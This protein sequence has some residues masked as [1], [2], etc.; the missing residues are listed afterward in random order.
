[1][2]LR[3]QLDSWN[4]GG[5]CGSDLQV[6]WKSVARS[7]LS[8]SCKHALGVGASSACTPSMASPHS[9]HTIMHPTTHTN[10]YI[11]QLCLICSTPASRP[12]SA[13]HAGQPGYRVASPS[14]SCCT[15][16]QAA[17]GEACMSKS[18]HAWHPGCPMMC[19]TPTVTSH[20]LTV[21]SRHRRLTSA[22]A[23]E[24]VHPPWSSVQHA[25]SSRSEAGRQ[26]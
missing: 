8:V 14:P 21:M 13:Q 5:H 19:P 1:M 3:S 20:L 16:T 4:T 9:G 12:S 11:S 10:F 15:T 6:S 17:A 22:P 26:T 25:C 2:G 24:A 23:P 7:H 18:M